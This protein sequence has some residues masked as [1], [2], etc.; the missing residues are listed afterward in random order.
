MVLQRKGSAL[1]EHK[2]CMVGTGRLFHRRPPKYKSGQEKTYHNPS[3]R[4]T[5][6]GFHFQG[7]KS[8][9]MNR[10]FKQK[11][12]ADY[13]F[14]IDLVGK[15]LHEFRKDRKESLK[16]VGKAVGLPPRIIRKMEKGLLNFRP[17][18]LFRLCNYYGISVSY[19]F[20]HNE[21][22]VDELP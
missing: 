11:V 22:I 12:K 8:S 1:A 14:S 9:I 4:R 10:L 13:L 16:T 6:K 18:R 20:R 15:R 19:I 21:I 17:S 2:R 3:S 5:L 7:Q